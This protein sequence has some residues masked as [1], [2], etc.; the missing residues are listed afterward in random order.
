MLDNLKSGLQDA[1][2]KFGGNDEIDEQSVKEFVK[3]L[4]RSLL[5]ALSLIHI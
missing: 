2:K 3:D 1:I 4:Q 5:Q